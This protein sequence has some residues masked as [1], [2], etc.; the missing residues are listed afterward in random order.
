MAQL[1]HT[2]RTGLEADG[3]RRSPGTFRWVIC[4]LLFLATMIN[5]MDRQVIGL[6]K[7]QLSHEF[8]WTNTVYGNITAVF[9]LAY[10]FGYLFGG[11][12][13]DK[14]GVKRGLPL[15]AFV[16][17]LFAAFHGLARSVTSFYIA[18]AGLGLSEG[19]NFPA[20]IRTVGEWFPVRERALATGLFNSAS[21]VGAIV[22]P[23][24]IP[25]I[26][27]H[28]GWPTAFYVTGALGLVWIALWAVTYQPPE[29]HPRLS[30]A[31]RLY[32]QDGRAAGAASTTAVPWLRLLRHRATWGYLCASVLPTWVW[33][34]YLFWVPDFLFK[35]FHLTQTQ[36][37]VRTSVVYL[38]SIVGS[39]GAGWLAAKL[40]SRGWSLNAARKGSLLVCALCALPVFSAALVSNSWV[41]VLVVG[42]AAAGHQ[43]WSANLYTF[44]SDTMPKRAISSVVG[45]GGFASGLVSTF[46]QKQVGHILDT[47]HSYVPVFVTASTMYLLALLCLHLFVPRIEPDTPSAFV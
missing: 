26:A 18:R 6:L 31:E 29:T 7:P 3:P 34:F 12:L 9:S 45:L 14:I 30:P 15:A 8:G 40:L 37:G 46:A 22:C 28:F 25:V 17:S 23:L 20:A 43:G 27:L 42:L 2:G 13:M 44:V 35:R 11:R 16:W 47:S 32:I 24:T 1:E 38:I 41:A 39:I 21:N 10:A 33:W 19:G 4:G 36:A 5:Y